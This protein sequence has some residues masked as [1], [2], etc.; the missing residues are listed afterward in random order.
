MHQRQ[1]HIGTSRA[2]ASGPNQ[3]K[4][5]IVAQRGLLRKTPSGSCI[6]AFEAP[7]DL[8]YPEL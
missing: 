3:G 8:G 4:Q 7:T 1:I 2:S 6:E 5:K